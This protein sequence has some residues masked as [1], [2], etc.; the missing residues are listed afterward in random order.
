MNTVWE[1]PRRHIH[2]Q[3]EA[4]LAV[5]TAYEK[6]GIGV[7]D[8]RWAVTAVPAVFLITLENGSQLRGYTFDGDDG[9]EWRVA[10]N[11]L[12]WGDDWH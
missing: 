10:H 12:G 6:A 7:S 1:E 2:S 9:I 4:L 11:K 8:F 3:V 5:V